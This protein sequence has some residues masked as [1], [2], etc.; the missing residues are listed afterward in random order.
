MG[1][2]FIPRS[3]LN[4]VGAVMLIGLQVVKLDGQ[5]GFRF[6]SGVDLIN[7]TATVTDRSGRFVADLR[8]SDFSVYDDDQRVDVT[9]FSADRAPVS[10]GIVLDTSGSMEGE[11]I[12]NARGAIERFLDRLTDPNDQVFLMGF[13]GDPVLIQDWT[14]A[15]NQLKERLG[16]IQTSG[17]TAMYDAVREAVRLAQAGRNRKKAIIII[18]DG[19]DSTSRAG[20]ADVQQA[21]RET[22][23]MVYAV[24]IDGKA[25]STISVQPPTTTWPLVPVPLSIPERGRPRWPMPPQLLPLAGRNANS[26]RLNVSALRGI[27]DSSGGRTEVVRNARDLDRATESIA[28]ELSKQYHLGYASPWESDDRWHTIRVEVRDRSVRVRARRG[29]VATS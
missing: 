18:S 5:E 20:A 12:T 4:A 26:E 2:S 27:T 22:E 28:E 25:E 15:R 3:V 13:S 1:P 19:N 11:K 17:G 8:Q 23:V 24:G 21:V 29:Y 7:V 6:R 9:Y 16:R 10:L 14:T